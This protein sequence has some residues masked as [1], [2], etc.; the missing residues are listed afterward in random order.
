MR[1]KTTQRRFA[2]RRDLNIVIAGTGV[3][4]P[5]PAIV[6]LRINIVE[7]RRAILVLELSYRAG[8]SHLPAEFFKTLFQPY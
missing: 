5:S 6:H 7:A 2:R 4:M 3:Y 1:N 8:A